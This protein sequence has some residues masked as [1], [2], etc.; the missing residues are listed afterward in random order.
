MASYIIDDDFVGIFDDYFSDQFC[1][2][3]IDLF[4]WRLE[5]SK[6]FERTEQKHIKDDA[7]TTLNPASIEQM[8]FGMDNVGSFL[9]E[10]NDVFWN[11]CYSE[12]T[13]KYSTLTDYSNHSIFTYKVQKT[14]PGQGYHV[15][16]C[17]DCNNFY[18]KRIGVYIL[19]LNDV[20]EGGETEF[21]YLKK[22]VEPRKGRLVIFP[23]NF[24]WTHRGNPPLSNEKYILTGWVS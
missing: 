21:L 9:Y 19:Y 1:D 10:F 22:R 6:T 15:W 24:P 12:Y 8:S 11:Q 5:N 13:N 4:E 7:A 20:A 17:E 16:H 2:G 14:L 18:S 3:I 23:P